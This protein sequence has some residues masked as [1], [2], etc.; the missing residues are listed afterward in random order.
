MKARLKKLSKVEFKKIYSEM[1]NSGWHNYDDYLKQ[2]KEL[3]NKNLLLKYDDTGY[4]NH[5]PYSLI[6]GRITNFYRE[7]LI[8]E[9]Q[10]KLRLL[11]EKTNT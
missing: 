4:N 11:N 2:Y 3:F 6:N 7:E 5:A 9:R 1:H 10:I 8:F